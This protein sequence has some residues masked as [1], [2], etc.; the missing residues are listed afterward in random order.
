MDGRGRDGEWMEGG[1]RV[2]NYQIIIDNYK[3]VIEV[4]LE[5]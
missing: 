1:K 3:M 4:E 2:S 5:V